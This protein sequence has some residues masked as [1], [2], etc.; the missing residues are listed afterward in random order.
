MENKNKFYGLLL[1]INELFFLSIQYAPSLEEA[2]GQAKFEFIKTNT[3]ITDLKESLVAIRIN[4]F[5]KKDLKQLIVEHKNFNNKD[6]EKIFIEH[7]KTEKEKA[8]KL[9]KKPVEIK[10]IEITQEEIK[11]MIMKEIVTKKDKDLLKQHKDLFNDNERK[12]LIEKIENKT[13]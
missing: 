2:V 8:K 5:T 1:E 13:N 12:Y 3:Q 10:K 7:K 4:L 9:I 11:N 6:L